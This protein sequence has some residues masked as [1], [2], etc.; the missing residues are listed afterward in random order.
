[1]AIRKSSNSG[2]PFGI[3]SGRPA[4]AQPGQPYFNGE[5]NRLELYT[6]NTGWQNIVQETPAVVSINGFAK[7]TTTSTITVNGTNFAV[8]CSVSV[9][10]SNGVETNAQSTTLVSIVQLTAV[11]PALN[12][13]YEPYDIKVVNP[14]NLYGILYDTLTVDNS[15][16]W[17]TSAGS[18]GTYTELSPISVTLTASDAVDTGSTTL[19]YSLTSGSLPNGLTL[20]SSGII[21]GTPTNITTNTT[22]NFTISVS[23]SQ[24][25][26]HRNFSIT[27]TDRG[28]VWSTTSPLPSFS[29]GTSYSTTLSATDD[30]GSVSYSLFSG[31]LPTGLSL[32]SSTGVISGTPSSSTNVTFT[33][34]AT[35]SLSAN[36]TDRQFTMLNVGPVWSATSSY[37]V[38]ISVSYS[39]QLSAT[40]DSGAAPT[41]SIASGTLP[42]GLSLSSSG[43][44]TGTSAAT[45][46]ISVTFRATDANGSYNDKAIS[47][48]MNVVNAWANIADTGYY[49]TEAIGGIYNGFLWVGG[50]QQPTVNNPDWKAINLVTG[51][52]TAKANCPVGRDEAMGHW[53]GSKFY[54]PGGYSNNSVV[55]TRFDVYDANTDSWS[56]LTSLSVGPTYARLGTD[57][58]NLYM[59]SEGQGFMQRYNI[60]SGTWTT[61]ATVPSGWSTGYPPQRLNYH[62]GKFYMISTNAS[63]NSGAGT[64]ISYDIASNSWQTNLALAGSRVNEYANYNFPSGKIGDKIYYFAHRTSQAMTSFYNITA[65]TWSDMALAQDFTAVGDSDGSSLYYWGGKKGTDNTTGNTF[66]K[67]YTPYP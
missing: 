59:V 12:P 20:S 27:I 36:Y 7:E 64:I 24:N 28:P 38:P 54:I 19:T 60:S 49:S 1:M 37:T 45:G 14:S 50:G 22:Y 35:D 55:N 16:I 43:L 17:G 25:T 41:Y 10:G 11:L 39:Q 23:D 18:L 48:V 15:P 31:S 3:N 46:T 47:F 51:A 58:T 33:I 29:S 32:N 26:I 57:G 4:N 5:A 6:Q 42:S 66:L 8:G 2:I 13:A 40:D 61:L 34:R 56:Q 44:I 62:N 21:S 65:N 53:V 30:N 52:V 63:I 67:K 9:I